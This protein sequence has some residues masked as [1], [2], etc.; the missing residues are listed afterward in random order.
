MTKTRVFA[1][2]GSARC[3]GEEPFEAAIDRTVVAGGLFDLF[4]RKRRI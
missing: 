3:G 2:D 1:A 4:H